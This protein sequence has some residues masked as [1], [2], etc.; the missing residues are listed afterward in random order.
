MMTNM[1]PDPEKTIYVFVDAAN[2][3]NIM[4]SK[5]RMIDYSKLKEFMVNTFDKEFCEVYYYESY[6]EA[7]TRSYDT[8]KKLNFFVYLKKGLGF[9]VKK[10][11][12]KQIHGNAGG[13]HYVVEKGNMDVEIAVDAIH[14]INNYGTAVFFTGDCDFLPVVNYIKGMGKK[15]FI[16]SSK[17]SI[18]SELKTGGSG[19]F[20]LA[21]QE[22]IWGAELKHREKQP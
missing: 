21:D 6:P 14:H 13:N 8:T 15:A 2:V 16:F 3:W 9:I 4:K 5:Q 1:K 18:S 12:L 17:G 7:G 10:K 22:F 11:P 20:D 19:Y